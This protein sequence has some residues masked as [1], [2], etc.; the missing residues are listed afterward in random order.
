MYMTVAVQA[1][2]ARLKVLGLRAESGMSSSSGLMNYS[3]HQ[4][5]WS[6]N[7]RVVVERMFWNFIWYDG[8]S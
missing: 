8:L 3:I 6:M 2:S 5:Q 1:L 4:A 7:E